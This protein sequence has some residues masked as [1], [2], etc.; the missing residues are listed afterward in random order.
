MVNLPD[1]LY[2]YRQ[3]QSSVSRQLLGGWFEYRDTILDLARE[4]ETS[5]SDRLQRGETVT[6]THVP[7][8]QEQRHLAYYHYHQWAHHALNN[9]DFSLAREYALAAIGHQPWQLAAW[10]TLARALFKR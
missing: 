10:K 6:I 9:R 2:L 3:H 4:R 5:G 1:V 7:R 8:A